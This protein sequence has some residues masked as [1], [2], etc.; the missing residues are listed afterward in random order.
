M[1]AWAQGP[2][3]WH[4]HGLPAGFSGY[5]CFLPQ[6]KDMNMRMIEDPNVLLDVPAKDI[7]EAYSCLGHIIVSTV[8]LE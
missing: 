8:R 5:S 2:S 1:L 7:S 6:T 3:M 4:L